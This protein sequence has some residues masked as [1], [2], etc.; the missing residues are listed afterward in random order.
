MTVVVARSIDEAIIFFKA[1]YNW[2]ESDKDRINEEDICV[3]LVLENM[4]DR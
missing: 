1:T 4:G 2:E 3:G